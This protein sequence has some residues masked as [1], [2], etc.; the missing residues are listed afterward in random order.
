M[1]IKHYIPYYPSLVL[2]KPRKARL[3]LTERLLMGRKESNHTNKQTSVEVLI[4]SALEAL[5]MSI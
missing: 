5:L 4:G 3:C 2:V 1:L